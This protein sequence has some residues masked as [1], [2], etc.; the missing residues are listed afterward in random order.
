LQALASGPLSRAALARHLGLQSPQLLDTRHL[1]NAGYVQRSALTPTDILHVTGEFVA[2][3]VDAAAHGLVVFSELYG[4]PQDEIICGVR[5]QIV[6]RLCMQVLTSAYSLPP[7][8]ITGCDCPLCTEILGAALSEDDGR[9]VHVHFRYD[10]DLVAIGAPVRPFFP[11]VAE[12]LGANLIIPEHA[13]VANA[14]GAAASEVIVHEKV[15]VRPG[16]IDNFVL[17]SR[18]QRTEYREL[19]DAISAAGAA[20][21][22][23]ALRRARGAGADDPRIRTDVNRREVRIA[24]GSLQLIEVAVTATA[25]GRPMLTQ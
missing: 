15:I 6:R 11:A 24:D 22:D 3:D 14:I 16:E 19:E 9:P 23:L 20:A 13:E 2:W 17:H 1:E 18:E 25:A 8:D 10:H 4:A 12:R 5:E 7:H 21:E